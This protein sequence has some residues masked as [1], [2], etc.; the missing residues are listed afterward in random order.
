MKPG[1]IEEAVMECYRELFAASTPKGDFDELV[2]N[3]EIIDGKKHIPFMDY[4]ISGTDM[5]R[6]IN[7]VADRY[8]IKGYTKRQFYVTIYLGCSP[9]TKKS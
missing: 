8:K 4:E 6:I 1:K 5:E 2:E 9:K 3:A 7:N